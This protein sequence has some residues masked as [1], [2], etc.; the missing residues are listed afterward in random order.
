MFLFLAIIMLIA[1][2]PLLMG[3]FQ[4]Y[5][6]VGIGNVYFAKGLPDEGIIGMPG[7]FTTDIFNI[8]IVRM[9][10]LY[11]EPVTLSYFF[12]AAFIVSYAVKWTKSVIGSLMMTFLM[13]V[14][15]VLTGGKG[16]MLVL[17]FLVIAFLLFKIFSS[18]L[19][20]MK[21]ASSFWIATLLSLIIVGVFSNYYGQEYA[22]PAAAHFDTINQTWAAILQTPLGHGLA[23]GGYNQANANLSDIESSGAESAM[24][25]FGYQLGI[26]GLIALFLC[27]Y[28]MT[29]LAISDFFD[30]EYLVLGF[31]PFALFI[32]SLFQLNTY[33]PQAIVPFMLISGSIAGFSDDRRRS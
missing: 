20:H 14:G 26:Q 19:M 16:G 23:Q 3:G 1:G 11:Y 28:E 10:S 22:G 18:K 13:G 15:L 30:K 25:S 5:S 33:T 27:F 4:L 29:K 17:V 7:R 31:I 21:I 9:G 2:I 12:S 8:H 32:V 24:M 6:F